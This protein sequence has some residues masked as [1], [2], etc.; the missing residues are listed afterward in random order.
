MI[1]K[2]VAPGPD[3]CRVRDI[4]FDRHMV[5]LKTPTTM[6]RV[7]L[8]PEDGKWVFPSLILEGHSTAEHMH[9]WSSP[10]AADAD[11][12]QESLSHWAANGTVEVLVCENN[13][14]LLTLM[15]QVV[16]NIKARDG[17]KK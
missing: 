8:S 9:R 16:N 10:I 12:L 15:T 7:F 11:S 13:D 5:V 3:T 14:D 6:A 17:G 2:V 1:R 4:D